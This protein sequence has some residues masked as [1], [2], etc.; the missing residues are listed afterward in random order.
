[1]IMDMEQSLGTEHRK[2]PK[3]IEACR[4][5][6]R[7]KCRC[8]P[9]AGST[10]CHRCIILS[11]SC[12]LER[13]NT[14]IASYFGDSYPSAHALES[15][16]LQEPHTLESQVNISGLSLEDAVILVLDATRSM[17]N[18]TLPMTFVKEITKCNNGAEVA[19]EEPSHSL[20]GGNLLSADEIQHMLNVFND[21]YV[22][23][24]NLL[25]RL[26]Q[27]HDTSLEDFQTLVCCTV[28]SRHLPKDALHG[29]QLRLQRLAK[30]A[31]LGKVFNATREP[32]IDSAYG[33]LALSMWL[34][35]ISSTRSD[36]LDGVPLV[37]GAAQ[38]AIA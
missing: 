35:S 36:I 27:A 15:F 32:S 22:L 38:M 16:V 34:P 1:M 6:R 19:P 31:A 26:L 37:Q 29:I 14:L 21:Y 33:L 23:C 25:N 20:H 8:E 12:S 7:A 2:R 17:H 13:F 3:V 10:R 28:S 30:H 4:G 11:I 9:E 24:L 5:C 18:L